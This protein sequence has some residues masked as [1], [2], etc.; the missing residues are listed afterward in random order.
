[1]PLDK[2]DEALALFREFAD[3][4]QGHYGC[5]F[6]DITISASDPEQLVIFEVW[7]SKAALDAHA[8]APGAMDLIM[9][10]FA[11]GASDFGVQEIH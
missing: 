11:L 9:K 10:L 3:I 6:Y 7:D 4:T 1:M 5:Q 2:R 8:A